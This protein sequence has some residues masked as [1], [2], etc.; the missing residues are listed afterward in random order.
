[1][2]ANLASEANA[3]KINQRFKELEISIAD[4]SIRVKTQE[5]TIANQQSLIE[6]QNQVI[7]QLYVSKYGSGPTV[8]E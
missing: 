8:V 6:K 4:L 2:S 5:N 7:A 3:L 1:M